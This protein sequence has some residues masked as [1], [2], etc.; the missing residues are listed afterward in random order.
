MFEHS[1]S[2]FHTICFSFTVWFRDDIR[3]GVSVSTVVRPHKQR[4]RDEIG[5][6]KIHQILPSTS[7][8]T[9]EEHRCLVFH[10]GHNRKNI[11]GIECDNHRFLITF[12]PPDGVHDE[13][14]E[15]PYRRRISRIQ[16]GLFQHVRF[17]GKFS[18]V[19]AIY[20]RV[21]VSVSLRNT[22]NF[23]FEI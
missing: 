16:L 9:R 6:K 10:T 5:R 22:I 3:I 15:E 2:S 17:P 23:L 21:G 20:E 8:A 13:N 18:T 14:I 19:V 1:F 7:T 12:H 11:R 4:I